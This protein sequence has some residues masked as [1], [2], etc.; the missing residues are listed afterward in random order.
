MRAAIVGTGFYV[1]D[2]VIPNS[3]FDDGKP[4]Y[5]YDKDGNR[6]PETDPV[7]RLVDPYKCKIV[8]GE[9][10]REK[11]S[12]IRERREAAPHEEL[13]HL[14]WRAGEAA[15]KNAGL[16]ASDLTGIVIATVTARSTFPSAA[17]EVQNLLGADSVRYTHDI[18]NACA[19]F[20]RALDI[21]RKN[22]ESDGRGIYLVIGAEVLTRVTDYEGRDINANLFGD[23]AGAVVL[24]PCSDGEGI[25][26]SAN[27]SDPSKGR[28][29]YITRDHRGFLRMGNGPAV[30]V[31]AVPSMCAVTEELLEKARWKTDDVDYFVY[32][33]AN[34]RITKAITKQ[35][36][37]HPDKVGNNIAK[38]GNVSAATCPILLAEA[39]DS[40]VVTK[41]SKVT[42]VAFGSG[43]T[44]SGVAVQF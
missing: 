2:G 32:H 8:T 25:L 38:Y 39:R 28:I 22:I 10:I 27:R 15:L 34:E 21:A 12:G 36:G 23:G 13:H 31:N 43:L 37:A 24:A 35:L 1:P 42:I 5:F 4:W 3:R 17:I 44:T 18:N 26:A 20:P 19:G 40:G 30:F 14:A 33:Q 7:N 41:G 16:S 6:L 9:Y 11:L 29:E